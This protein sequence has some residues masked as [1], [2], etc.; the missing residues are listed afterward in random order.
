MLLP[1]EII[2]KKRQ[3]QELSLEEIDFLIQSYTRGEL[4]D[5]QMSAWL[6]T[7]FFNGM[8]EKEVLPS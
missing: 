5:Y 2:R 4:P 6:M 1:Y 8:T 7:V 3:A